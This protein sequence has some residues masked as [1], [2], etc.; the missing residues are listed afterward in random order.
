MSKDGKCT[1][2]CVKLSNLISYYFDHS[3]FDV[4]VD[5]LQKCNTDHNKM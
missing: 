2:C 5:V 1:E 4:L 3:R